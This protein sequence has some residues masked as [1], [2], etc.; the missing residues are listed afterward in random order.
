MK[1]KKNGAAEYRTVEE[2]RN[3]FFLIPRK[4]PFRSPAEEKSGCHFQ[5]VFSG[6]SREASFHFCQK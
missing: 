5:I 6:V 3:R 1:Q 4:Q 2:K